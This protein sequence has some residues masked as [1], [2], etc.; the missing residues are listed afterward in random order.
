MFVMLTNQGEVYWAG[1]NKQ[2]APALVNIPGDSRAIAVGATTDGFGVACENGEVYGFNTFVESDQK[3]TN[4]NMTRVPQ[5]VFG[6][7]KVTT[8]GG[9]YGGRFAITE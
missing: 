2:M 8:L 3:F 5:G 1:L 6:N 4:I 9:K 7:R